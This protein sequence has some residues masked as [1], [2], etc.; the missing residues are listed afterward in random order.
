MLMA[1]VMKRKY[2]S[3]GSKKKKPDPQAHKAASC[4]DTGVGRCS[5]YFI[6]GNS[7]VHS[8]P[9][10]SSGLGPAGSECIANSDSVIFI[11]Q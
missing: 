1:D 6:T 10:Y 7:P 11:M 8:S 4:R 5:K 9:A 3:K 2:A